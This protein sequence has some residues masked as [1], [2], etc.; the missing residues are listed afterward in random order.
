MSHH[1]P[2][3]LSSRTPFQHGYVT[4]DVDRAVE[5]FQALLGISRFAV[6]DWTL[7]PVSPRGPMRIEARIA[8]AFVD[9][10]MIEIIQPVAGDEGIYSAPL[11]ETGFGLAFH[12]FGYALDAAADWSAFRSQVADGDVLFENRAATSYLYV[13]THGELGH[14]LE[15]VQFDPERFARLREQIPSN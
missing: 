12:H 13:D 15:Y 11:P 14:Y 7:T 10:L 4:T 6:D 2:T 3:H 8:F 1:E 9:D 5:R